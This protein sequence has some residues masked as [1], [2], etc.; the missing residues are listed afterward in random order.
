MHQSSS[1]AEGP[2]GHLRSV[3]EEG[4]LSVDSIVARE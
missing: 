1:S 4:H 3:A 2:V